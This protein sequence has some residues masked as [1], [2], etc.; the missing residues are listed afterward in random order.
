[1]LNL[2]PKKSNYSNAMER[3]R[4]TD[5]YNID[6]LEAIQNTKML[7]DNNK[8]EMLTEYEKYLKDPSDYWQNKRHKLEEL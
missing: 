2:E 5:N 4:K 6:F 7:Q 3:A 8:K 1:M